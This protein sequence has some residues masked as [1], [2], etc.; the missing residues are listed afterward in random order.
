MKFSVSNLFRSLLVV[1]IL[2]KTGPLSH[3]QHGHLNAGAVGTN[4]M[5][6]LYFVN[7]AIFTPESGYVKPMNFMTS[8]TYSNYYA[9]NISIT[10]LPATLAN[11]G[12]AFNAPAL[13]S[14]IVAEITSVEGPDGGA[15]GFWEAG[16]KV[17]TYSVPVGTTNGTGRIEL[18]DISA[19]AGLPDADPHGHIHGRQFTL[20][21]PG[22]YKVGFTLYDVAE[23]YPVHSPS[24]IFY[25]NFASGNRFESIKLTNGMVQLSLAATA[26]SNYWVEVAPALGASNQWLKV[27]EN[28][29]ASTNATVFIHSNAAPTGKYF[30]RIVEN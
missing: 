20:S 4:L 18:S 27:S 25:I 21:K 10:A 8:G 1:F 19:G 23:Y 15:F 2:C 17:P 12:P 22:L 28:L 7:G 11:G 29:G 9:G 16:A 14:F 6:K 3:G 26:S 5:D 13:G 30:Y 24:D